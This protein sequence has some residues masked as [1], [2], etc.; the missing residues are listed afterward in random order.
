MESTAAF[1]KRRQRKDDSF[2][3]VNNAE[4]VEM[5]NTNTEETTDDT[6]K[7]RKVVKAKRTVQQKPLVDEDGNEIEFEGDSIEEEEEEIVVENKYDKELEDDDQ[8]EDEESEEEGQESKQKKKVIW[9]ESV[10]PLKEGE[11]LVFD[12]SAYTMLHRAK[13]EW[14]FL[15]IDILLRD[16]QDLS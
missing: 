16:R 14:P 3:A 12:N 13:V 8:W 15:S 9:D 4:D 1:K 11:E 5:I 10:G 6:L 2:T 7:Q